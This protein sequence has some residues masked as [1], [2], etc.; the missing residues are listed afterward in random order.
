MQREPA[1]RTAG[2][3]DNM[4]ASGPADVVSMSEKQHEDEMNLQD[5]M[6][7][8]SGKESYSLEG[9]LVVSYAYDSVFGYPEDIPEE[10]VVRFRRRADLIDDVD[11]C[12]PVNIDDMS[13]VRFV[14]NLGEVPIRR[15]HERLRRKAW[16]KKILALAV[17]AVA[18]AACLYLFSGKPEFLSW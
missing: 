8:R 14:R 18:L 9:E 11:F 2:T 10:L 5:S 13:R 1:G 16:P 12:V 7:V 17:S 15:E 4:P 3:G 6:P